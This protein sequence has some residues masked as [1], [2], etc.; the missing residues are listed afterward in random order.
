MQRIVQDLLIL[1]LDPDPLSLMR[2]N[3]P[4]V[5]PLLDNR[6]NQE[7]YDA[8]RNREEGVDTYIEPHFGVHGHTFGVI[9]LIVFDCPKIYL[10]ELGA[11]FV[12]DPPGWICVY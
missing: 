4:R 6:P 1:S 12:P 3:F 7:N 2:R 10:S 11:F 5:N 9:V 8:D